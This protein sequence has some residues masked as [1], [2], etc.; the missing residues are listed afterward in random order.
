[1]KAA[2]FLGK[3]QLEIQNQEVPVPGIG[4]ILIKVK[5]CGICGT[6]QHIFH[7]QPGSA[8]VVPPTILGHEFSGEVVSV[9]EKVKGLQQGDRVSIDPNIY[10]G[11]CSY[12]RNGKKHLCENLEALGVTRNGG[13]A[14]YC[15][16]PAA[17]CYKV[18]NSIS[19]EEASLIE[20]LGCVIHGIEQ[21]KIQPGSSVLVI[22]G[23]FIGQLMLQMTKMYGANPVVISEPDETKHSLLYDYGAD[24]VVSPLS[25]TFDDWV[26]QTGGFD[27]VI[28]C[29]GRKET[30]EQAVKASQKGAQILFFGVAAPDT[31]ISISPFEVF[32]KELKISGS[33][34]NPD[35]HEKA[36][37]LIA[38]GKIRVNRSISHTF[39]LDEI[40]DAMVNYPRMH[41]TK[42]VIVYE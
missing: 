23:G 21:I 12:C 31:K 30:M 16:V 32:A 26:S 42:G 33:F 19:F 38:Q 13:M 29:V 1:M 25:G 37:S 35:T 40:P 22:G 3:H 17:N 9:G 11:I 7:G 2:V 28:E 5:A 8:E 34:I 10:C 39:Q 6:D 41:V 20:P 27:I 4:E 36:I 14:E 15:V 24:Q 18:P